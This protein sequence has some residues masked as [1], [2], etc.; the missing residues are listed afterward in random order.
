[1][2][3]LV[4]YYA[5]FSADVNNLELSRNVRNVYQADD[6]YF[7]SHSIDKVLYV[8]KTKT[9]SVCGFVI[10]DS[11]C[12]LKKV[13]T[14]IVSSVGPCSIGIFTR[15]VFHTKFRIRDDLL[16]LD[17]IHYR[18]A[19][20]Q[21]VGL[22]LNLYEPTIHEALI[23]KWSIFRDGFVATF[24]LRTDGDCVI[25]CDTRNCGDSSLKVYRD[26]AQEIKDHVASLL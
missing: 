20:Q 16:N 18:M 6:G 23:L 12:D 22:V 2:L 7:V 26:R 13:R 5:E 3:A 19:L 14:R 25:V 9:V 15:L 17:R 8:F 11:P 4:K 10:D 24:H 1:M 21:P